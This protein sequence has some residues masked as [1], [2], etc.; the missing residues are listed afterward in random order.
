MKDEKQLTVA[1]PIEPV[2]MFSISAFELMDLS[3]PVPMAVQLRQ[4]LND[5]GFKFTDDGK[6]SSITNEKPVPL[7]E[8]I[9]WHDVS[10]HT[11]HYKQIL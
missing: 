7:G 6:F 2:V 5:A 1:S 11:T 3:G 4:K 10:S 8:F 9:S